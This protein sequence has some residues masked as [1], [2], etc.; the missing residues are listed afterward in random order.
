M[1]TLTDPKKVLRIVTAAKVAGPLL[2]AGAMKASTTVRGLLDE[3]RAQKLGVPVESVAAYK[4]PAGPSRARIAGLSAAIQDLRS[5]RSG[6]L[7][8]V[9]F[10]NTANARLIDL[11]AALD[12]TASM[13]P[14]TQRTAIRAVASELNQID[15][16]LMTFLVGPP[17]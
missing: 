11:T 1:T 12:A 10:T 13:P 9:S 17:S 16:E 15:A 7:P 5:R 14:G 4:G 8:V 6:E 3:K 2:A